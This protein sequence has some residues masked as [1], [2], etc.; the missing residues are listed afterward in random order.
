MDSKIEQCV[1][2]LIF[3]RFK[4]KSSKIFVKLKKVF[5]NEFVSRA[6]VFKWARW[7]KEGRSVYDNERLGVPLRMQRSQMK[8]MLV[9]F[10]DV[11]GI[12][13]HEF[14]PPNPPTANLAPYN[15]FLFTKLK[16]VLKGIWFYDL[17]KIK[18]KGVSTLQVTW[19]NH[20]SGQAKWL[21]VW[22]LDRA[23]CLIRALNVFLNALPMFSIFLV[24]IFV[25]RPLPPILIAGP[26]HSILR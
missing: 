5:R 21:D 19:P 26:S 20:W 23:T 4:R 13:H 9:C 10:F 22:Q 15:F 14:V 12:V 1:D 7:L 17:E 24:M 16:S 25:T 8:V 3:D 2:I 6:C 18:A 11:H